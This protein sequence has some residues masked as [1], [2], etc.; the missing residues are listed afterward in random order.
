MY[1]WR[2]SPEFHTIS[3]ICIEIQIPQNKLLHV[4]V[5]S[6][7][8]SKDKNMVKPILETNKMG[9]TYTI[10]KTKLFRLFWEIWAEIYK[11]NMEN[12]SNFHH[13]RSLKSPDQLKI[14]ILSN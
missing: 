8:T 3:R 5:Y 11:K 10:E 9:L 12:L 7:L 1:E 6:E 2:K 4:F 14:D 13:F